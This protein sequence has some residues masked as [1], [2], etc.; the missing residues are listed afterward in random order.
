MIE[1]FATELKKTFMEK[2]KKTNFDL[3]EVLE[4]I[5]EYGIDSLSPEEKYFLKN[6]PK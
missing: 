4:K 6:I 1:G 5:S 2:T 3:D